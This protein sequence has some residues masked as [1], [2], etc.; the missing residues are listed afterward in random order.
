M[1]KENSQDQIVS[2]IPASECEV[3][4]PE[5]DEKRWRKLRREHSRIRQEMVALYK[6]HTP[7]Y[8]EGGWSS[9]LDPKC[10]YAVLK[11]R[12]EALFS[13]KPNL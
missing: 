5:L 10:P 11:R 4:D 1:L 2:Y 13:R 9:K 6:R 8:I 3:I 12:I 7:R